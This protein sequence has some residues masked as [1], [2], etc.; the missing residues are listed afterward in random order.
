MSAMDW[1]ADRKHRAHEKVHDRSTFCRKCGVGVKDCS[2]CPA[3]GC[4]TE[5]SLPE[6]VIKCESCHKLRI[7]Q[8]KVCHHCGHSDS[9]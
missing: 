2:F 7:K 6:G 3:C 8:D 5:V 4:S 9:K 1:E